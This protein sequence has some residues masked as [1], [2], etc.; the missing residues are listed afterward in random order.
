M[1]RK[2]S[3]RRRKERTAL[4]TNYSVTVSSPESLTPKSDEFSPLQNPVSTDNSDSYSIGNNNNGNSNSNINNNSKQQ[5]MNLGN[6]KE[7]DQSFPL[8]KNLDAIATIRTLASEQDSTL[9]PNN[10]L[11]SLTSPAADDDYSLVGFNAIDLG[12]FQSG[13]QI[14]TA[15]MNGYFSGSGAPSNGSGGGIKQQ[16]QTSASLSNGGLE[17][18]VNVNGVA[19]SSLLNNNNTDTFNANTIAYSPGGGLSM[20]DFNFSLNSSNVTSI[21]GDESPANSLSGGS[22]P[23]TK[24][25]SLMSPAFMGLEDESV[26]STNNL[27]VGGG[28]GGNSFNTHTDN[29]NGQTTLNDGSYLDLSSINPPSSIFHD[30]SLVRSSSLSKRRSLSGS[31]NGV[32]KSLKS[33]ASGHHPHQQKNPYRTN[34]LSRTLSNST[35]AIGGVSSTLPLDTTTLSSPTV[36]SFAPN[37]F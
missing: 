13:A 17:K 35:T 37:F 8:S 25:D 15:A 5:I 16:Q 20:R 27:L 29:I 4:S 10:D 24:Y 2:K 3:T 12:P 11:A 26:N 36:D 33:P 34:S 30:T 19:I 1:R 9:L 14:A 32:H 22:P 31:V 6:I 7:E 21:A 28:L 23:F 18:N